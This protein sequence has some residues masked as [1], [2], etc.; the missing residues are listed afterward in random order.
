M[1]SKEHIY[2]GIEADEPHTAAMSHPQRSKDESRM[3]QDNLVELFLASGAK[4]KYLYQFMITSS[5]QWADMK[6]Y[7]GLVDLKWSSGMT[8]KVVVNPG[9]NYTVEVQLPRKNMPDLGDTFMF[10]ITRHRHLKDTKLKV[11]TPFYTWS[12]FAGSIRAEKCGIITGVKQPENLLDDGNFARFSGTEKGQRSR[13]NG[14]SRVKVQFDR[15]SF[16]TGGAS[17]IMDSVNKDLTQ[18]FGSLKPKTRYRFSFYL[19]LEN[20]KKLKSYAGLGVMVGFGN[21]KSFRAF[22]SLLAGD[23]PWRRYVFEITTPDVI[24]NP[25][26]WFYFRNA[27]GRVL[28][29]EVKLTEIK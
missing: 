6:H 13:W 18:W 7:P 14:A 3:W 5:G 11:L 27:S 8:F 21:S 25:A 24:K 2:I 26:V 15:K 9:K 10:N 28:V 23:T 17:V 19:K 16:V 22:R 1:H 20:V 12:A 4:A 29:D